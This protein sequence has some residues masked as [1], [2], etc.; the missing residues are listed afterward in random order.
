MTSTKRYAL[1]GTG[2]RAAFHYMSIVR[3]FQKTANLVSF[4]DL[5]QTRMDVA[6]Q[7]ISKLG[8][9][10]VSTYKSIYFDQ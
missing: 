5:V 1:V 4:C 8:A 10:P 2:G 9:D 7:R 6:N 3:D